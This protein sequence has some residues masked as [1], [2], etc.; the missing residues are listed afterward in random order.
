VKL[1]FLGSPAFAVPSIEALR[2]AGHE[3]SL[4]VTQPDRPAGRGR[5]STPSPVAAYARQRGLPVWE[6]S[7]LKG[8]EAEVRLRAVGADTMALAAFAAL[9]PARR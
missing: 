5:K 9:V 4:V 6:A 2:V 3:V 8:A 7:S 1:V